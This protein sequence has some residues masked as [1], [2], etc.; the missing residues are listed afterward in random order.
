MISTK[1]IFIKLVCAQQ[2]FV[3]N[4]YTDFH[5]NPKNFLVYYARSV[6]DG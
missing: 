2:M 6:I 5:E 3:N 1:T 4:S